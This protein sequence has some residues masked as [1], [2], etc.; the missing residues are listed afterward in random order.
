[1]DS[2]SSKMNK[3]TILMSFDMCHYKFTIQRSHFHFCYPLMHWLFNRSITGMLLID[4]TMFFLHF[5][6]IY[7]QLRRA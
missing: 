5:V 6:M 2:Y 3:I 1:M 7:L 4:C